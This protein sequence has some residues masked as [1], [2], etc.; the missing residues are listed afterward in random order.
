MGVE[1]D[2]GA[3]AGELLGDEHDLS[4]VVRHVLDRVEQDTGAGA[5]D[6]LDRVDSGEVVVGEA[7]GD[8]LACGHDVVQPS[9]E[10]RG[11]PTFRGG[12]LL[13]AT[14]L[15]LGAAETGGDGGVWVPAD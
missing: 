15:V 9:H 2:L 14:A 3:L 12:E 11:V 8:G 6:A 13:A 1:L 5:R 10:R 7:G 4:G